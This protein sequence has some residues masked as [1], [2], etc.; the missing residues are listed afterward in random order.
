[1]MKPSASRWLDCT[2]FSAIF[3]RRR[4]PIPCRASAAPPFDILL[5]LVGQRLQHLTRAGRTRSRCR[6]AR[7]HV[8]LQMDGKLSLAGQGCIL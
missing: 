5:A 8:V 1:L 3:C 2:G 4:V 6:S 7:H